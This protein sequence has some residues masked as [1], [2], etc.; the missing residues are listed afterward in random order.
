MNCQTIK[1]RL[2][3]SE[4]PRRPGADLRGHLDACTDCRHWQ[5]RLAR[6][7]AGLARLPAPPSNA[8]ADLLRRLREAGPVP[9]V[10]SAA[11]SGILRPVRT[12]FDPQ[13]ASRWRA[14]RAAVA[15]A[16]ML[17]FMGWLAVRGPRD[18]RHDPRV[19]RAA[20]D[21]LVERLVQ[22]NVR[23]AGARS[24]RERVEDLGGLAAALQAETQAMARMLQRKDLLELAQ[25]YQDVVSG[26]LVEQ[27]RA[28]PA[29]ER[30]VALAAAGRLARAVR[31][32]E[33]VAQDVPAAADPLLIIA[34][35]AQE[36]SQQIFPGATATG[37]G[38]PARPEDW[39]AQRLEQRRRNLPLLGSLVDGSLKL[40]RP[41]DPGPLRRAERCLDPVRAVGRDVREA[42]EANE[43]ARAAELADDLSRLL[44]EGVA[45]NL[46]A[47]RRQTPPGSTLE[48]DMRRVFE[49][50]EQAVLPAR[51]TLRRVAQGDAGDLRHA[52][53]TVRAAWASLEQASK[54]GP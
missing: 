3:A 30:R 22:S 48:A 24:P 1:R 13:Y 46:E 27:A 25:L 4:D 37:D 21:R 50:A 10:G 41:D 43:G 8:R 42:A 18:G 29:E 33:E 35:A 19:A 28:L 7:E 26:G 44:R 47:A 39:N 36:G 31:D 11:D 51:D 23:L 16:V 53:Q 32:A 20:P 49:Q 9:R 5:Q 14:I 12:L 52:Y 38:V 6:T 54:T 45:A 17:L 2:L 40:V 34:R 15:A